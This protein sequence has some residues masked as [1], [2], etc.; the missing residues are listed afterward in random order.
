[1]YFNDV[2]ATWT[3]VGTKHVEKGGGNNDG[4]E[5]EAADLALGGVSMQLQCCHFSHLNIPI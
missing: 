5:H 2:S 3:K 4:N 1:M